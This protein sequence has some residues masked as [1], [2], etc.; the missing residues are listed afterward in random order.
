MASSSCVLIVSSTTGSCQRGL[1]LRP[2]LGDRVV[3]APEVPATMR[4]LQLQT[5]LT[6]GLKILLRA[7]REGL[8][9]DSSAQ[10]ERPF[11]RGLLRAAQAERARRAG[12]KPEG[13]RDRP[14]QPARQG[15]HTVQTHLL[16]PDFFQ[17]IG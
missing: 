15:T 14:A 3:G 1:H 12:L 13:P 17:L 7:Q 6:P 10:G 11:Y 16:K 9:K 2:G 8:P 5:L 4:L